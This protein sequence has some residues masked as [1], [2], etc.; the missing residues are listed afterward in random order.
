M[1]ARII[2]SIILTALIAIFATDYSYIVKFFLYLIPYLIISYDLIKKSYR[3]ILKGQIFDENFLMVVAS[4]GAFLLAYFD[5]NGRGDYLEAVAVVLFFQIGEFFEG[6]IVN[7][8]R[9][10]IGDLIDLTETVAY[11]EQNNEIRRVDA[12]T[13][14]IGSIVVVKP[15][16]KIPID[17]IVVD[18]NSVLNTSALTGESLPQRVE[19]GSEVL[20]GSINVNAVIKIKTTKL[21]EDSTAA[22]ILELVENSSSNKAGSERFISKFARYYTPFVCYSALVLAFVPPLYIKLFTAGE[23]DLF[24]WI[25]RALTFLVISCPCALVVSIPLTFFAAIGGAS[26]NGILV[27][28]SNYLEK[29][30]K[31]KYVIMDKTGT[32]TH[33]NFVVTKILNNIIAPDL[34]LKY[35]AYAE[36]ASSHPIALSIV[37]AYAQ[38]IDQGLITSIEEYSGN[39]IKAQ[40][41]GKTILVGNKRLLELNGVDYKEADVEEIGTLIY[42][43]IEQKFV[44]SILITDQIKE[45]SFETIKELNRLSLKKLVMLTGD[46]KKIAISVAKSLGIHELYCELLPAEKVQYLEDLTKEKKASECTV[47]VGDGINDAPVLSVAD[48][49]VAMGGVGSDAA[50]EAADVVIMDDNPLKIAKSIVIGKKCMRVT[51]ENIFFALGIKIAC[52]ILGAIGFASLWLAIFA[53]V[54][55]LILVILNALRAMFIPNFKHE[56]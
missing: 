1:L 18:G 19:I 52:L 15:G 23:V 6:Y 25:Y 46:N 49:G 40:I 4:I 36:S 22:K 54:G 56:E 47:F 16:A 51:Y 17:G 29:L 20:S 44:G 8:S 45:T 53:D 50:I 38:K 48:V 37:K 24:E 14:K 26:R 13:V 33:G 41:D 12:D 31:A 2:I 9:K 3:N 11:I 55:V 42:V 28:G 7:R 34:L 43:A 10:H 35:A 27:K 30:A 21:Y 5:P 32:L 39:G